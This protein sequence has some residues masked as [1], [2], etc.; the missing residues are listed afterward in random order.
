MLFKNWHTDFFS[1]T[2]IDSGLENNSGTGLQVSAHRTACPLQR[3][4]VRTPG[5]V[6]RGWYHYDNHPGIAQAA[7]I[8]GK[9]Q[10]RG[11]GQL[12]PVHFTTRVTAIAV[13][14]QFLLVEVKT[15]SPALAPER[16]RERQTNIPQAH[17][18]HRHWC[19]HTLPTRPFK[20]V[21]AVPFC[22]ARLT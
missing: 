5:R 11:R 16:H 13:V 9:L 22:A 17:D 21:S 14:S 12:L 2:G 19:L 6:Y 3:A 1:A 20:P 10:Q 15:D 4:E 8:A 7:G 18:G